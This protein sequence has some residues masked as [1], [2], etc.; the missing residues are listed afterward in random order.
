M[1]MF[2]SQLSSSSNPPIRAS[3]SSSSFS[4]QQK[5]AQSVGIR[6]RVI[7]PMNLCTAMEKRNRRV[8]SIGAPLGTDQ[9]QR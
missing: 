7:F 4:N 3:S 2:P 5:L 6:A 8:K 1:Y 9:Q